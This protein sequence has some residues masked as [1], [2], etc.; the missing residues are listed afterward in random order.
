MR[1]LFITDFT[2]QFPNRLLRG[3]LRYSEESGEHWVVCRMPS[4][5]MRQVGIRK[6]V[7]Q[8]VQWHAEVVIGQFEPGDNYGLFQKKGMVVLAQDYIRKFP[9][10]PNIT[11][12]YRRMG[13]MAADR[14]I[15]RG[16]REFAFFGNN[17]MCWSDERMEGFRDRLEE[18]GFHGH[19]HIYE[20][21]NRVSNLWFYDRKRLTDWLSGLPK[22]VGIMACDDNQASILVAAC[23][24]IGIRVPFDAAIIGV[25]NDEIVCSMTEP[26]LSSIDVDIERGGYESARLAEQMFREGNYVGRDIVLQ[27]LSIVTRT[28]SNV[29]ATRDTGIHSALEFINSNIDHKILVTDVLKHVPMSRRLLEQRFLKATG[30]TIYQ[31]I[32]RLRVD[33]FAQLLLETS[34]SIA[35]IA[36]RMDEPDPKNLSRRFQAL[37]GC[38]PS[39]FR[40]QNL[41]KL[42]V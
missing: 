20:G 29:M 6:V 13:A 26:S 39:A 10:I 37:K 27:P 3:I 19:I 32:S 33:R 12:D 36:A 34:D 9:D 16:F 15:A 5:Y 40:K 22:P 35:D 41:R 11:A 24:V 4:A 17:G 28:S 18:S 31:Y 25:D 7:D 42:G 1:L 8:A 2:E 21:R 30:S 14:F 23:S 38:T